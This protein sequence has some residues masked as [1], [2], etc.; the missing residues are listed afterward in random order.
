[1][2]ALCLQDYERDEDERS[3]FLKDHFL[4]YVDICLAVDEASAEVSCTYSHVQLLKS[5]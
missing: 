1:M 4:Q 2:D 5:A 3:T